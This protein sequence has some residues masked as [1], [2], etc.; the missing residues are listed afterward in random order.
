LRIL[1]KKDMGGTNGIGPV[2]Q[3]GEGRYEVCGSKVG[4]QTSNLE[5][6]SGEAP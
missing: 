6:L 2:A 3:T 5:P 4:P 1:E